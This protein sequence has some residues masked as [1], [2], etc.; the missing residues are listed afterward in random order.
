MKGDELDAVLDDALASYT[1]REPR[2][3]F[4]VRAMARVRAEGPAQRWSWRS[5]ATAALALTILAAT[6]VMWRNE[7]E[8]PVQVHIAK[9][10]PV[11]PA[12]RKVE[13]PCVVKRVPRRD[14]LTPEQRALLAFAQQAPEAAR[15]MAQPDIPLEIEEINIRPLQID[16]LEIG[17]I[18]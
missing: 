3:G 13:R 6:V 9:R 10:V 18:E 12:I 2:E 17:E 15:Q 14:S 5:L 1:L 7:A 11:V 4:S 16:G 8:A